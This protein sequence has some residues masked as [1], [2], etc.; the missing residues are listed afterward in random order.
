MRWY[1]VPTLAGPSALVLGDL[2]FVVD[3]GSA[4]QNRAAARSAF[5]AAKRLAKPP[6]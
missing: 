4:E 5:A 2:V 6:Q 3:C 1:V